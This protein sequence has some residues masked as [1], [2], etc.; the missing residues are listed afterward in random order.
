MKARFASGAGGDLAAVVSLAAHFRAARAH[1]ARR[2]SGHVSNGDYTDQ[3][4]HA[5][6]VG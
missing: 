3:G 6:G 5:S 2:I 4:V 1:C